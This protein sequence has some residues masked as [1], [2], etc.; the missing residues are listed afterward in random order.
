MQSFYDKSDKFFEGSIPKNL[1]VFLKLFKKV[2]SFEPISI[3]L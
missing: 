3:K 2:L 1:Y